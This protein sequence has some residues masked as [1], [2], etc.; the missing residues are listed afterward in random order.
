M[1]MPPALTDVVVESTHGADPD[2]VAGVLEALGRY[3]AALLGNDVEALVA[4]FAPGD[5]T[6]RADTGEAVAGHDRIAAFRRRRTQVPQRRVEHVHVVVLGPALATTIATTRR[7]NGLTGL[8]T[9]VWEKGSTTWRIKVAHLSNAQPATPAPGIGPHPDPATWRVVGDPLVA[10]RE[11]GPLTGRTIAVKDTIAVAGHAIGAGNPVYLAGATP[12]ATHSWVVDRLLSLGSS[13]R[14]IAQT[15]ELAFGLTGTNVHYGSPAHPTDAGL[16]VGGSSSGPASAVSRGLVDLGVGTDTAGSIRVPASYCGIHGLRTTHGALPLD[17]ILPLAPTFDVVGLLARDAR[18]LH[19]TAVRLLPGSDAVEQVV[20]AVDLIAL[21]DPATAGRVL[22]ASRELAARA[23]C[24]WTESS[25]FLPDE[26]DDLLAMFRVLQ[27]AEV[28][29]QHGAWVSGHPGVLGP[30]VA[31]RFRAAAELSPTEIAEAR[32]RYAEVREQLRSRVPR[33]V[34]V[35]APA[36]VGPAPTIL[37]TDADKQRERVANLRLS[38]FASLAGLPVVV[39]PTPGP[40]PPVGLSLTGWP[41]SDPAL[42]GAAQRAD[43][44]GTTNGAR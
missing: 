3:E 14:G 34:A 17:G 23:G 33:G 7:A 30:G 39:V 22:S 4:A 25:L 21:A 2:L 18:T 11:P 13:V 26:L 38:F 31:S 12:A 28:W 32:A 20:A 44:V 36:T 8:Q 19:E 24:D 1:T 41:D 9:Q 40:H 15:D 16:V 43:E 10:P 6:V 35:A 42:T 29:E 37:R 5:D 27:L